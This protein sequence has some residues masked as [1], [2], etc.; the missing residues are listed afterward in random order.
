MR[1]AKLS[2]SPKNHKRALSCRA[3]VRPDLVE[4]NA[5]LSDTG[6]PIGLPASYTRRRLVQGNKCG[7]LNRVG[8]AEYENVA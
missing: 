4:S 2:V 7:A 8:A 3:A 6:F 5:A 1:K